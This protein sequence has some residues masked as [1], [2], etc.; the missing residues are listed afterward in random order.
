MAGF[1]IT[2]IR[3]TDN[4]QIPEPSSIVLLPLAVFCV[5][6]LRLGDCP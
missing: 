5:S 6:K 1:R 2:E 3:V 4:G